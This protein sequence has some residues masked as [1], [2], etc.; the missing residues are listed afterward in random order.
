MHDPIKENLEEY[1]FGVL[2]E[3]QSKAF[4]AHLAACQD[5]RREVG[6]MQAQSS[7]LK[8]LRAPSGME[9]AP[10]FY[11]RVMESVQSQGRP[12]IW[13]F[14]VDPVAGKRLMYVTMT[15]LVL[16]STYLVATRPAAPTYAEAAATPEK[17][18]VEA[19]PSVGADQQRD[20][21]VVLVELVSSRQ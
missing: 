13:S 14:F 9:P 3:S 5:C 4:E 12:S 20:R 2:G 8:G 6:Q 16:L 11:A 1:L 18:L 19:Q 17:I 7:L 10:G 21:D 15:L